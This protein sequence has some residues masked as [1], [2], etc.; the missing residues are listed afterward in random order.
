M[1]CYI[2]GLEYTFLK[3][4]AAFLFSVVKKNCRGYRVYLVGSGPGFRFTRNYT[5]MLQG[6]GV[7]AKKVHGCVFLSGAREMSALINW[8]MVSGRAGCIYSLYILSTW[9]GKCYKNLG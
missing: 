1:K 4:L 8:L 9:N 5:F 3:F 6:D 2:D 7:R